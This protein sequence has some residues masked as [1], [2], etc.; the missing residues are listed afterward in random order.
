MIELIKRLMA[1]LSAEK[2]A[3]SVEDASFE[4]LSLGLSTASADLGIH[5]TVP[6]EI[7]ITRIGVRAKALSERTISKARGDLAFNADKLQLELDAA[8][9]SGM[10]E[11][12]ALKQIQGRVK[13]L[14]TDSLKDWELQRLVRDQFLVATKEGRRLG[15]EQGGVQWRRWKAHR[16]SKTGDDS[17]R[18]DGQ[19]TGINE[20]YTD[21][22]TGEKYMLPH[23]RPNDR[24]YEIPL[25]KLPKTS[26]ERDGLTYAKGG[27]GSGIKG[28][29]TRHPNRI[30]FSLNVPEGY[31]LW[32][33]S[34][35]E[36]IDRVNIRNKFSD[37]E[38]A[39]KESKTSAPKGI[40]HHPPFSKESIAELRKEMKKGTKIDMPF[41]EYREDKLSSQEGFHRALIAK[42]LGISYSSKDHYIEHGGK[43]P[44]A[45]LGKLP[46]FKIASKQPE[47]QIPSIRDIAKGGI[48]SG[49]KG[50]TTAKNLSGSIKRYEDVPEKVGKVLLRYEYMEHLNEHQLESFRKERLSSSE[51]ALEFYK[52]RVLD[53]EVSYDMADEDEEKEARAELDAHKKVVKDIEVVIKLLEEAF[54]SGEKKI[55]IDKTISIAHTTGKYAILGDKGGKGRKKTESRI[56]KHLN[57][58]RD[59]TVHK[60]HSS[61]NL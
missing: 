12:E 48:G 7:A 47:E 34:P 13:S 14:F 60:V 27:E 16:D 61:H 40:L 37:A 10:S 36:Y 30:R 31:S 9:K 51:E 26:V 46:D 32:W 58:I 49:I 53:Y 1:L 23:I 54:S 24:C 33:M 43:I 25:F 18:M 41:L 20:P 45:V 42:Y 57:Y 59:Q 55:A 21:P 28:H 11:V 3:N 5:T 17:K 56:T 22:K 38:I 29:T 35:Q 6:D 52:D 19:I 50:H 2:I 15:W 44:V 39:A 4:G 8:I